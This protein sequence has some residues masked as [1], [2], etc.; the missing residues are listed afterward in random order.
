MLRQLSEIIGDVPD[1]QVTHTEPSLL[2][3]QYRLVWLRKSVGK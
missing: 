2:R 1:L 3:G